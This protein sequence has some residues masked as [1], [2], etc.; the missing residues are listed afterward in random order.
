MPNRAPLIFS[1]TTTYE[2]WSA[3]ILVRFERFGHPKADKHVRAPE[4]VSSPI[5][6]KAI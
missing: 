4:N 6:K 2:E 1:K 3:D 5:I